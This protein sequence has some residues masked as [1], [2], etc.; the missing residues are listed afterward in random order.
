MR[1]KTYYRATPRYPDD[2]GLESLS[3]KAAEGYILA[4]LMQGEC[5]ED[6]LNALTPADF[7]EPINGHIFRHIG[8]L[9]AA[10]QDIQAFRLSQALADDPA[11]MGD[12]NEYGKRTRA[13][14]N[15]EEAQIRSLQSEK[16][17]EMLSTDIASGS[18]CL[19]N[20]AS[21]RDKKAKRAAKIAAYQLANIQSPGGADRAVLAE[22][23]DSL[24][25]IMAGDTGGNLFKAETEETIGAEIAATPQ[26]IGTGYYLFTAEG[27]R[28]ELL[29]PPGAVTLVCGLPGHC[30]S[31]MLRNLAL[32]IAK[33][34]P[35]DTLYFSFEES[36]AK[37]EA[38]LL[39]AYIGVELQAPG[40][41]G[42]GSNIRAI[43]DYYR[44]GE[45]RYIQGGAIADF[46][47]KRAEYMQMRTSGK[48]RVF[49]PEYN[50][51]ELVAAINAYRAKRAVSAIFVDYVQYL[52][53]GRNL[54]RVEELKDIAQSLLNLAKASGI[55]VVAAAQY[56]RSVSGPWAL[57]G[58]TIAESQDL[59]RYA[60]TIV[61]LWNG[62]KADDIRQAE[63]DQKARGKF[64]DFIEGKPGKL[65]AIL[66]KS[67]E[68]E[69]GAEAFLTFNG[70]I[71]LIGDSVQ[72]ATDLPADDAGNGGKVDL[73]NYF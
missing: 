62:A 20:I 45:T 55:P 6:I 37:T 43:E 54:S 70:K 5:V 51:A 17:A 29:I 31:V 71:G 57:S 10:G 48:L 42:K 16:L 23:I 44:T 68:V 2:L 41:A 1:D 30:K 61:G 3:D 33:T 58:G 32:R 12:F 28:V 14:W 69:P 53:S 56:N 22:V 18:Q 24:Q 8:E 63:A 47:K 4:C 25:G 39:S 73:E 66:N 19:G 7:S 65:Y 15:D 35:G 27:Q 11:A 13:G 52:K 9:R 40:D 72:D 46:H 60:D 36:K 49:S 21:I 67:R 34:L 50:A 59:T 64:A 26:G 38:R